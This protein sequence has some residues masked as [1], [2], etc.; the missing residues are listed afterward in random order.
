MMIAHWG[1]G[2]PKVKPPDVPNVETGMT[3]SDVTSVRAEALFAS[4]LQP[5]DTATSV[6]IRTTIH[7]TL[8]RLGVRRCALIVASDFGDHPDLAV[9]RM[10]WV[11][12]TIRNAYPCV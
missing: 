8:R 2:T 10:S 9:E 7:T 5:S 1:N 12:K 3:S 6:Q 4:P 11:I